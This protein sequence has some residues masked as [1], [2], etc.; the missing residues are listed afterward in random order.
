MNT[1]VDAI[2]RLTDQLEHATGLSQRKAIETAIA[3]EL[4]N[5]TYA[6]RQQVTK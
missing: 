1:Y 6:I 3:R 2:R 5:V 4:E